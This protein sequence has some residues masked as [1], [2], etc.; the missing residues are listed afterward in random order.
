MDEVESLS[1]DLNE[2]WFDQHRE[3]FKKDAIQQDGLHCDLSI[4][5]LR[6]DAEHP[7]HTINVDFELDSG[8]RIEI[9]GDIVDYVHADEDT[10]EK[11]A[12]MTHWKQY[13]T[14]YIKIPIWS[15]PLEIQKK[16]H[17]RYEKAIKD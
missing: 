10:E 8:D 14:F 2:K 7:Q 16:I 4:D 6:D 11:P 12:E 9:M 1:I 5:L 17:D 15:I 13:A 3:Q